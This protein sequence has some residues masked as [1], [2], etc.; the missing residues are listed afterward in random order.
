[1][2]SGYRLRQATRHDEPF[3]VDML[4]EALFVPP[5][6]A[7]PDR[8][9]L[10][11]PE[12]ARYVRAFGGRPGDLGWVAERPGAGPVGAAWVRRFSAD[13]PGYGYVDDDT[14]ELSIALRPEH[15]GAGVGGLLLEHVL[16]AAPRCSLSVDVRNPAIRLYERFG[17][18]VVSR[19][20]TSVTMLRA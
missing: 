18:E 7:P 15:R 1:M 19:S 4:Y 11:R 9:V 12:V 5:G 8:S 6:E 16:A 14:P 13:A 3:L 2:T 20:G 17:F 10:D